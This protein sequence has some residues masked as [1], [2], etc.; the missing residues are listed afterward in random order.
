MTEHERLIA[1]LDT[2]IRSGLKKNWSTPWNGTQLKVVGIT[3]KIF[4]VCPKITNNWPN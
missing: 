3:D 4:A 1:V 2:N